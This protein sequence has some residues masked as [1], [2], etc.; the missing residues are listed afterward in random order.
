M[1]AAR[2][3]AL[4]GR[5]RASSLG[6]LQQRAWAIDWCFVC[7]RIDAAASVGSRGSIHRFCSREVS[8]CR[9]GS[10]L[11][12]RVALG[13]SLDARGSANGP[14]GDFAASP[15]VVSR[16]QSR[17]RPGVVSVIPLMR[18]VNLGCSEDAG[19]HQNPTICDVDRG[20]G[21]GTGLENVKPTDAQSV[22]KPPPRRR[23]GAAYAGKPQGCFLESPH[24]RQPLSTAS[25]KKEGPGQP[26]A[27]RFT[28]TRQPARP[29]ASDG[30]RAGFCK[31][32]DR[33]RG[34][35]NFWPDWKLAHRPAGAWPARH[36][37]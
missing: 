29:A 10:R 32:F 14:L 26:A 17:F 30:P 6:S 12:R 7:L 3:I 27:T 11:W 34:S 25:S 13:C 37:V 19:V 20:R 28:E 35:P 8:A 16:L 2:G 5:V 18:T 24:L 22:P 36:R 33:L 1:V 15:R 23:C 21:Q 31:R 4:G 9:V